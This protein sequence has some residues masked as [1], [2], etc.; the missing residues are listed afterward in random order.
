MMLKDRSFQSVFLNRSIP[1]VFLVKKKRV[2][3]VSL[4]SACYICV[5]YREV[6]PQ[7]SVHFCTCIQNSLSLFKWQ[8]TIGPYLLVCRHGGMLI[9][10]VFFLILQRN[11]DPNDLFCKLTLLSFRYM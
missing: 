11:L 5:A 3:F 7:R 9:N 4:R 8:T 2:V 10:G 1:A 6:V